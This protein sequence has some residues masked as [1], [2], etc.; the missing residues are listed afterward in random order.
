MVRAPIEAPEP[1]TASEP[2]SAETLASALVEPGD[3]GAGWSVTRMPD[4]PE[5]WTGM[6][7][8]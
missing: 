3:L 8:A 5:L 6:L 1:T 4:F 2:L 7:G